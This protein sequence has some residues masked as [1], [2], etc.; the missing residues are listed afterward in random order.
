MAGTSH[1]FVRS[2]SLRHSEPRSRRRI[3]GLSRG[4]T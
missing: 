2:T 1:R 4:G 3:T